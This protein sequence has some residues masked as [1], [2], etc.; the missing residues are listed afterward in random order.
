MTED[1]NNISELSGDEL[2]AL[3]RRLQER[4]RKIEMEMHSRRVAHNS[5]EKIGPSEHK[6]SQG[7]KGDG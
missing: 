7:E 6:K 2:M 4:L 1:N 3:Y 5:L